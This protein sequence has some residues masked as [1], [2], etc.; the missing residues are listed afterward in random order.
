MPGTSPTTCA[1]SRCS[2]IAMRCRAGGGIRR[3]E[4]AAVEADS[5]A[6]DQLLQRLVDVPTPA[7]PTPRA[8]GFTPLPVAA[9]AGEGATS[10]GAHSG[11]ATTD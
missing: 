6:V 4:A 3:A 11:T 2:S 9:P 7:G 1:P 5:V 10:G 8:L